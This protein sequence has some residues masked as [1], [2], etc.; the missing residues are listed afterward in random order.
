MPDCFKIVCI[1]LLVTGLLFSRFCYAEEYIFSA[2]PTDDRK[3]SIALYTPIAEYLSAVTGEKFVY[4]YSQNW[5]VYIS[6]GM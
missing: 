1:W 5:L 6:S 2:P 3:T 4:R